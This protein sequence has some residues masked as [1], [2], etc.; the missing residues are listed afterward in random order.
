MTSETNAEAEE[1]DVIESPGEYVEQT[2]LARVFEAPSRAKII[3][4]FLDVDRPINPSTIAEMAGISVGSWYEHEEDLIRLG[5]IE[6][7]DTAGNSP[8]YAMPDPEDDL[9]VEWLHKFNWWTGAVLRGGDPP[10]PDTE[11]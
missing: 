5:L 7:V 1:R 2:P 9:R 10:T 8:L 6:K 3:A 11:A 4:V